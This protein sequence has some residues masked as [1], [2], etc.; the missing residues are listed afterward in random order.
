MMIQP[1]QNNPL[2]IQPYPATPSAPTIQPY[3]ATA[4]V[5]T[6]SLLD[7]LTN[8]SSTPTIQ[9]Y[10]STGG[11]MP[12]VQPSPDGGN[13]LEALL[14]HLINTEW[15]QPTPGSGGG[16]LSIQPYPASPSASP[17][18]PTNPTNPINPISGEPYGDEFLNNKGKVRMG[19]VR[20]AAREPRR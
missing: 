7:Y 8:A 2:T 12:N 17:T 15:P 14:G 20:R 4:P 5:Q 10:P 1:Y 18:N 13:G 11:E 16:D 6:G 9:P 3:P 19:M